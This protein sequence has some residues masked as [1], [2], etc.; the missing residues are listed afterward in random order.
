LAP[1]EP[2]ERAAELQLMLDQV[3]FQVAVS[4]NA[5]LSMSEI[6]IEIETATGVL[7]WENV[8]GSFFHFRSRHEDRV[9]LDRETTLRQDT[10][11]AFAAALGEPHRSPAIDTR[12]YDILDRAYGRS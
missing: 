4:W 3:E 7:R 5:P 12:V 6:G 9:L 8:D 11:R 1:E 10:L 2:V